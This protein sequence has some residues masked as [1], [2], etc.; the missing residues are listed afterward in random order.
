MYSEIFP[1]VHVVYALQ[2]QLCIEYKNKN[3][4]PLMPTGKMTML[5]II[6][7]PTEVFTAPR[8][9]AVS[10][11]STYSFV[12]ICVFYAFYYSLEAVTL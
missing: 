4:G 1:P 8:I 6:H 3:L 7:V 2:F 9:N 12:A 10:S 5:E 11:I